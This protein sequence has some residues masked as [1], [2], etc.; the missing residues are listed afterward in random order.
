MRHDV[1]HFDVLSNVLRKIIIVIICLFFLIIQFIR[2]YKGHTTFILWNRYKFLSMEEIQSYRCWALIWKLCVWEEV[3]THTLC[4][5]FN[6]IS[7]KQNETAK[8]TCHTANSSHDTIESVFTHTHTRTHLND[9]LFVILPS[10]ISLQWKNAY[11][12][13]YKKHQITKEPWQ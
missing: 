11:S 1:D 6:Y 4:H 9:N 10:G 7:I 8:T 12:M 5:S 13:Y 2:V 3:H